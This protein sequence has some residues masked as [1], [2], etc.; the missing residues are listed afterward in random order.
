MISR[1]PGDAA[2]VEPELDDPLHVAAR[3]QL[4]PIRQIA[5]QGDVDLAPARHCTWVGALSVVDTDRR[6]R[7]AVGEPEDPSWKPPLLDDRVSTRR[8]AT[9]R[10]VPSRRVRRRGR[11]QQSVARGPLVLLS[12][13]GPG[14]AA[15]LVERSDGG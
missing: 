10:G 13:G 4:E 11:A 9:W 2:V 8:P 1:N 12:A 3:D 7:P 5:G 14:H 6:H 15:A